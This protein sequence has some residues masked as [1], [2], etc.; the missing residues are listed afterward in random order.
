MRTEK[1]PDSSFGVIDEVC[2]CRYLYIYI[3]IYIISSQDN[4]KDSLEI[5][6]DPLRRGNLKIDDDPM[7]VGY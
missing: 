3:Y 6:N 1:N 7:N 2:P 5:N 4:D